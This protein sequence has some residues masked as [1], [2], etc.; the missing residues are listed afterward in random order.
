MKK[1]LAIVLALVVVLG[2]CACGGNGSGNGGG[3]DV[4]ADGKVKLSIGI[5]TNALVLDHD[6][7]ALTRWIEETCNVELKFQ[8]YSGGTDVTTQITSTVAAREDLPDILFGIELG[9]SIVS[10]YGKDGYLVDL[11]DYFA[12]KEGKSKN[13]WDRM[14]NELTQQEQDYV[15]RRMTDAASGKIYGVPCVETSMIDTMNYMMWINQEWL[16][17]L[18]LKAPTNNE[19]LLKV[20]RAFKENDC[21]GD[22]DPTNEIPLFGSHQ[23]GLSANVIDWLIN[24]HIYYNEARN[25]QVKDG[26]LVSTY[27]QD[28]YREALKFINTLTKEKL[29]T[30]MAW[31]ATGSDVKQIATPSSGKAMVGMFCGHLTLHTAMGNEVLYQYVPLKTWGNAV[32][33]DIGFGLTTFITNSCKNPEKAFEMLMT[34]WTW[35][36]SMR[37]RYGEKDV[38]WT[39]ADEGAKSD[40]GLDATYKLLSDPLTQQS[41]AKWAKIAST[42]NIYAEGETAQI[43]QQLDEWTAKK[44]AMHA[45]ASRL[46]DEAAA[47]NHKPEEICP[48][49]THTE[50]EN[51]NTSALRTNVNTAVEKAQTDFCK[52]DRDPFSDTEWNK[53]LKELDDLGIA[54]YAQYMQVAYDRS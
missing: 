23:A 42:L 9:D 43:T 22:G 3:D 15:L 54:T 35:D 13:F 47:E 11:S 45:E 50:E 14:T 19:E 37:I 36:G 20:L 39:E 33:K 32:R 48:Y 2:L 24:L 4:T 18:N 41:T 53:Y 25:W 30:S 16:D 10:R 7:N 38:N 26:K 28:A 1:F 51:A 17:K 5:P 46:F 49:L 8:E 44:S 34:M 21:N 31:S 29:L 52:G 40:L 12:D 6:K 27:T